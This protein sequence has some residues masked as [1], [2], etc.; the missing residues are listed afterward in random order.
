MTE[1]QSSSPSGEMPVPTAFQILC[2]SLGAQVQM[3]LGLIADP[4]EKKVRVELDAARQGI[5]LLAMLEEKTAGNLDDAETKLLSQLLAQL[6][7][8][9]VE[10]LKQ[11]K[12]GEGHAEPEVAESPPQDE[13][14]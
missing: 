9:Y 13:A 3:A 2:G 14:S 11:Q 7:M 5:D 12:D 1:D 10:R 6:R 4:V 8:L